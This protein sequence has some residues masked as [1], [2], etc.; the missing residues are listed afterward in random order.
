MIGCWRMLDRF[1]WSIGGRCWTLS[2]VL[3]QFN[4]CIHRVAQPMLRSHGLQ[5]YGK[6]A[7][8][9]Q[10]G[11]SRSRDILGREVWWCRHR[12]GRWRWLREERS[13]GTDHEEGRLAQTFGMDWCLKVS[14]HWKLILKAFYF[15]NW[16]MILHH[17][18]VICWE[19]LGHLQNITWNLNMSRPGG[20]TASR[21]WSS[22]HCPATLAIQIFSWIWGSDV[23]GYLWLFQGSPS[24]WNG[25]NW[26]QT[27]VEM[28]PSQCSSC[29]WI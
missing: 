9:Q 16:F 22:D 26:G 5:G 25:M 3:W 18:H 7:G 20:H 1:R 17:V 11:A 21:F 27:C 29:I 6:E 15:I 23:L 14:F 28:L 10:E 4:C 13:R 24:W 8:E 12:H 2:K 19:M